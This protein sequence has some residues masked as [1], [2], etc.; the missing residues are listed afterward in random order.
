MTKKR[1][2]EP[3]RPLHP[4]QYQI[5]SYGTAPLVSDE[6]DFDLGMEATCTLRRVI[7]RTP[8]CVEPAA[9]ACRLACCGSIKVV[10]N[11]HRDIPTSVYPNQ[12]ICTKCGVSGPEITQTWPI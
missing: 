12:F 3:P 1:K 2:I 11:K 6:I 10:C 5:N 4:I 7:R 8:F 9:W